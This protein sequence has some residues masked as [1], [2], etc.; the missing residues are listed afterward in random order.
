MRTI[1]V[2]ILLS[3]MCH[4]TLGKELVY[5]WKMSGNEIIYDTTDSASGITGRVKRKGY[6]ILD[7]D[8]ELD[9]V[10]SAIEILFRKEKGSRIIKFCHKEFLNGDFTLKRKNDQK[11]EIIEISSVGENYIG[12]VKKGIKL[13]DKTVLSFPRSFKGKAVWKNIYDSGAVSF[14]DAKISMKFNKKKTYLLDQY[15]DENVSTENKNDTENNNRYK[16][17]FSPKEAE[18]EEIEDFRSIYSFSS[19]GYSGLFEW[20]A[21]GTSENGEQTIQYVFPTEDG[22]EGEVLTT[23]GNG[24]TYWTTVNSRD[25]YLLNRSNHIGSQKAETISDFSD[26]VTA[27]LNDSDID[28][29]I[30]NNITEHI[31]MEQLIAA[32]SDYFKD[33]GTELDESITNNIDATTIIDNMETTDIQSLA[34]KLAGTNLTNL[35]NALGN[36][37]KNNTGATTIPTVN[38]DSDDGY[39]V[40]S[41]WCNTTDDKSY[42]CLDETVGTAVWKEISPPD[43]D[44][45]PGF[46][47][48]V[49][50]N[51]KLSY[52]TVT[53]AIDLDSVNTKLSQMTL[54]GGDTVHLSNMKEAVSAIL[55]YMHN[56][57]GVAPPIYDKNDL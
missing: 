19:S 41:L 11:G 42:I 38:D 47:A 28:Q 1:S 35:K 36:E 30:I 34:D 46:D 12:K 24:T 31:D 27:I 26:A 44:S 6:I 22:Q 8:S 20:L 55:D 45:V 17:L 9:A 56:T 18:Y 3:V 23:D 29:D 14:G 43:A 57:M 53:V 13:F 48:R 16:V 33:N 21:V 52:L 39:S 2:I 32:M 54:D 4:F 37:T 51:T 49:A 40:G 50:S 25:E 15:S 10:D 7:Y 5:S